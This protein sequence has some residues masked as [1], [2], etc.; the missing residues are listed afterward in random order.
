MGQMSAAGT[1][2]QQARGSAKSN[3]PGKRPASC[4][5]SSLGREERN[6]S[7]IPQEDV[8]EFGDFFP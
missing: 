3:R 6:S 2:K 4:E 5:R 1:T 8:E 7:I